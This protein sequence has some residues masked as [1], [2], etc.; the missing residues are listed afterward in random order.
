MRQ[1]YGA[2][3]PSWYFFTVPCKRYLS[4]GFSKTVQIHC[5]KSTG[6]EE[7]NWRTVSFVSKHGDSW[8]PINRFVT[9]Q[10]T[11]PPID[12]IDTIVTIFFTWM[13]CSPFIGWFLLLLRNRFDDIP[14]MKIWRSFAWNFPLLLQDNMWTELCPICWETTF[15]SILGIPCATIWT[16]Y[17]ES[18]GDHMFVG[19]APLLFPCYCYCF[20]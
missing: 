6:L 7:P 1:W 16:K 11:P 8:V 20:V 14:F 3:G 19:G 5:T 13:V 17:S 15:R 4:Q 10:N 12:S 18:Y 2:V 9:E